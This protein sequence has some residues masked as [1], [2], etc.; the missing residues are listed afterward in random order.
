MI[1]TIDIGN[2]NIVLGG[3][4]NDEIV[5]RVNLTEKHGRRQRQ[6]GGIDC[7]SVAVLAAFIQEKDFSHHEYKKTHPGL[8]TFTKTLNCSM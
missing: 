6:A 5:W 2:S 1:L 4:K 3:A 8:L 7:Y